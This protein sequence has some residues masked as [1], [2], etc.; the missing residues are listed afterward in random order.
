MKRRAFFKLGVQKTAETVFQI[1]GA[2]AENDATRWIRPP[3]AL[4]ELGFLLACTRCDLCIDACQ[5]GVLF[6]LPARV[7]LRAAGT[8]AMDLVSL[9]CPMCEG[10]PCVA[11][12]KPKALHFSEPEP[13]APPARPRLAVV[14]IKTEDCLPYSGPE[15]G[16]CRSACPVPGALVFVGGAKPTINADLCTGC[17]L[18]RE[19]CIVTPKAIKV[20]SVGRSRERGDLG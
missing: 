5:P 11:A 16:A 14:T 7:G 4:D 10:W 3:F 1:V 17:A 9:G 12:C 19:A 15:C 18:C 8:P 20:V 13:E 6:R 2:V